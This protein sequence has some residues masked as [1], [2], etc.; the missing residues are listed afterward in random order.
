[1]SVTIKDVARIAGTSISTVSKV[2]NGSPTISE[3]TIKRVN[4]AIKSLNYVPNERG[5]N[6][7]R[8]S[9]KNVA[10]V[11]KV[12][13]D[14]AFYNPHLFEVMTGA[15]KA[16]SQRGY[17]MEFI[18]LNAPSIEEIKKIV[19]SKSVDGMMIHASALTP[20]IAKYIVKERFPHAVMGMPNFPNG[21]CWI[22][23]DNNLSGQLAA[24]HLLSIER[25]K[26]AFIGGKQNDLI[27]ELRLEGVDEELGHHMMSLPKEYIVKTASTQEDG[28]QATIKL[29]KNH[30]EIDAIICANNILDLGCINALNDLGKKIPEE[31]AVVTFDD[32]PYAII[33]K[34]Q[35]T[36]INIDVFDLGGQAARL[37]IEKINK[38]NYHFQS[39][40]TVPLLVI[41]ES[42]RK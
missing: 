17:T 33:T 15:G 41:R 24:K 27:S 32:Y 29:I 18:G 8:K 5:R 20:E 13:R 38:P 2:V 16:L 42:T 21:V 4:D 28:Y 19:D 7:A 26:I 9:T 37:L 36:A 11:T 25:Q 6:L 23:N 31:V 3:A 14:M 22:D 1:M 30:P 34:P 35:T 10:F 40:I 12:K 39:Y